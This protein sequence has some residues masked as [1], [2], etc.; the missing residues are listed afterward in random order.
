[1]TRPT[2]GGGYALQLPEASAL[3]GTHARG[4]V[5]S[6]QL[7]IQTLCYLEPA[8]TRATAPSAANVRGAEVP[9]VGVEL[10]CARWS[11]PSYEAVRGLR[12]GRL[13]PETYRSWRRPVLGSEGERNTF[14]RGPRNLWQRRADPVVIC[15]NTLQ[16][17]RDRQAGRGPPGC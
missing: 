16:V 13:D 5:G 15:P 17:G 14:L 3:Q 10:S 7:V 6:S 1:M 11:L 9:H 4:Y 8:A 2:F 12:L